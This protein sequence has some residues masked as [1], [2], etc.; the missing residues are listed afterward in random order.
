MLCT[1]S[2]QRCE[3]EE[4]AALDGDDDACATAEDMED[5]ASSCSD[6]SDVDAEQWEQGGDG[7]S[8]E[9]SL[10]MLKFL[11]PTEGCGGTLAP[12]H[13][14]AEVMEVRASLQHASE[15]GKSG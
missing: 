12:P 5:S 2:C 6:S 13:P 7:Y 1:H 10:W 9:Y 8:V 3:L 11:C 15:E 14:T 4:R